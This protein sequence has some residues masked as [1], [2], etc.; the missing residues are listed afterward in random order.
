M[1]TMDFPEFQGRSAETMRVAAVKQHAHQGSSCG[2]LSLILVLG[3]M[4]LIVEKEM[5]S[6]GHLSGRSHPN[7]GPGPIGRWYDW[8]GSEWHP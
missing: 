1:I 2:G 3:K 7:F 5:D 6:C 8:L 4:Q